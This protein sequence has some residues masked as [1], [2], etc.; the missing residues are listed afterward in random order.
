MLSDCC[1]SGLSDDFQKFPGGGGACSLT[2]LK[3]C[4]NCYA[5]NCGGPPTPILPEP[6]LLGSLVWLH[7]GS[8]LSDLIN[9]I[10]QDK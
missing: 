1:I 7:F 4:Y 3:I 8:H 5:L 9:L 10:V 2:P 6:A